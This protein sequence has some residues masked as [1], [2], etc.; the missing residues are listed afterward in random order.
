MRFR[1]NLSKNIVTLRKTMSSELV[2]QGQDSQVIPTASN[3]AD[4]LVT[5]P[6]QKTDVY[7][8]DEKAAPKKRGRKPDSKKAKSSDVAAVD[9]TAEA[10]GVTTLA[11][12]KNARNTIKIQKRTT[13]K[14]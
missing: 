2:V 1:I 9:A 13:K 5:A 10:E 7:S 11:H 3:I 8:M 6:I 12:L 14:G 4:V